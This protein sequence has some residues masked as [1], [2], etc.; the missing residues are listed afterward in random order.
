VTLDHDSMMIAGMRF[1][2]PDV[3]ARIQHALLRDGVVTLAD[4]LKRSER[5]VL[6][7]RGIGRV[8]LAEIVV[9]LKSL[10]LTLRE[11]RSW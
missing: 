11:E 7:I 6:E 3:E 1:S 5:E 8:C 10:G 9:K 2:N 4:L